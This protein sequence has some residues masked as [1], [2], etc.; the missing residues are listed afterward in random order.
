MTTINSAS[1]NIIFSVKT[2]DVARACYVAPPIPPDPAEDQTWSPISPTITYGSLPPAPTIIDTSPNQLIGCIE[3][4]GANVQGCLNALFPLAQD[5][6]GVVERTT[7]NIWKYDE[8]TW[9]NV[10]PNPGPTMVV[11]SVVPVW[12][13]TVILVAQTRS[14]IRIESFDYSLNL[15]TILPPIEFDNEALYFPVVPVYMPLGGALTLATLTPS[16]GQSTEVGDRF[17][18][19]EYSVIPEQWS[20]NGNPSRGIGNYPWTPSVILLRPNSSA[21]GFYYSPYSRLFDKSWKDPGFSD[22]DLAILLGSTGSPELT[23]G[24]LLSYNQDGFTVDGNYNESGVKTLAYS[25]PPLGTAVTNTNGNVTSIV[26]ADKSNFFNK[27]DYTGTGLSARTVGHGLGVI[28]SFFFIICKNNSNN[29]RVA[30]SAFSTDGRIGRLSDN[31][32]FT[33]SPTVLQSPTS[34]TIRLGTGTDNQVNLAGAAYSIYAFADKA[35][36]FKSGSYEG[37]GTE[38]RFINTDYTP[39]VILIRTPETSYIWDSYDEARS[40]N[41]KLPF[42]SG[43]EEDYDD[44]NPLVEIIT[45]GFNVYSNGSN[46]SDYDFNALGIKYTYLA[47]LKKPIKARIPATTISLYAHVPAFKKSLPLPNGFIITSSNP[48]GV[49]SLKIVSPVNIF[50][51]VLEVFVPLVLTPGNTTI[52]VLSTPSIQL[53]RFSNIEVA[54]LQEQFYSSNVSL[55]LHMDGANN[56]TNFI[57]SSINNF[58]VLVSGSAKMVTSD[59]VFGTSSLYIDGTE[60]CSISVPAGSSAMRMGSSNFTIEFRLKIVG[61]INS[62]SFGTLISIGAAGQNDAFGLYLSGTSLY[63]QFYFEDINS[64]SN[65]IFNYP[66]DSWSHVAVVRNGQNVS[67]YRNGVFQS[68]QTLGSGGV[69]LNLYNPRFYIGEAFGQ[70]TPPFYL[71]ELRLTKGIARYTSNFTPSSVAFPDRQLKT[72]NVTTIPSVINISIQKYPPVL[73]GVVTSEVLVP[74]V[75]ISISRLV[76]SIE[77]GV[78]VN[79]PVVSIVINAGTPKAGFISTQ[80]MSLFTLAEDTLLELLEFPAVYPDTEIEAPVASLTLSVWICEIVQQPTGISPPDLGLTLSTIAPSTSTG[81]SMIIPTASITLTGLV[82]SSVGLPPDPYLANVSFLLHAD[83]T[84]GSTTFADSSPSSLALTAF[85]NAQIS[86]AQSKFGG[87]SALFDGTGDYLARAYDAK[88]DFV[89]SDFTFEAWIYP[90]AFKAA[91][92]RIMSTGGG[93]VAWSNTTGIHTLIQFDPTGK[94]TLQLSN[95]TASPVSVNSTNGATLNVWSFISV[96]VSGSNAYIAVNGASST[97]ALATRARPSTDPQIA[98]GTIPGEAGAVGT[99][100]I[101]NMDEIRLTKG[102]ARYTSSYTAPVVPFSDY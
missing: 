57:D 74:S 30:G 41:K 31:Y 35:G 21:S 14:Y 5:G 51:V 86:T 7:G 18:G 79:V 4:V 68:S 44:I 49:G 91:G 88:F 3:R 19:Y 53:S 64:S 98:I 8:P 1:V 77:A 9:I 81:T 27:I 70:G 36:L 24:S 67:M 32:A 87:A 92:T 23:N 94:V 37:N 55:L 15:E 71:D 56:S 100:F 17:S 66:T 99:A 39:V 62:A 95:N 75:N 63:A 96:S 42:P 84:N 28:P 69:V 38:G 26:R 76:P 72:Y 58:P 54:P 97:H 52:H 60:N 47:F 20:G 73:V 59:K 82:P 80:G 12:N 22:P 102:I 16:I 48:A 2:P 45:N 13:E 85:G 78:A 61:P 43:I 65:Y 25:F 101:G 10:G 6:N 33:L 90:T 83:G 11:G 34:T 46:D 40:P 50:E 93:A 29:L 89:L